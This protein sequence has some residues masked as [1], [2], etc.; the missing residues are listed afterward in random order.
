MF[1]ITICLSKLLLLLLKVNLE[2]GEV[3]KYQNIL[4]YQRNQKSKR[5]KNHE[6][7]LSIQKRE[8]N[9]Q[10]EDFRETS[11]V[12]NGVG[13]TLSNSRGIVPTEHNCYLEH[14][15]YTELVRS[16]Q[17]VGDSQ[18]KIGSK[19]LSNKIS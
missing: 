17:S 11:L 3:I 4:L 6:K 8:V 15:P 18:S 16:P 7:L 1:I 19:F 5:V 9:F 12:W 13:Y 10:P 14:N 2:K